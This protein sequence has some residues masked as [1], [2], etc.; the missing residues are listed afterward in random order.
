MN[1]LFWNFFLNICK[2]THQ[3][4]I[5]LKKVTIKLEHSHIE[6]VKVDFVQKKPHHFMKYAQPPITFSSFGLYLEFV[7]LTH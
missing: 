2:N 7:I 5:I 6:K 1:L 3:I 4:I